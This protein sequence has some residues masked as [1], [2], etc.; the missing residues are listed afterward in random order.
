M[1]ATS[2]SDGDMPSR[3]ALVESQ[4]SAVT[5]SSPSAL[6]RATS[7]GALVNGC[8][9]SFQSAV[10]STVPRS[11]LMITAEGSGIEWDMLTSS[12]SNG[13]MV[14]RCPERHDMKR[15][16]REK[17]GLAEFRLQHRGGE[18]RRIDGHAAKPWP[19][20][21][22]GAEMILMR[23]GEEQGLQVRALSLEEADIGKDHVDA[24]L[25][26]AAEGD[27]QIDDEPL[28]VV[29]RP[30]AV[31]IEVHADLPHAAKGDEHELWP[32]SVGTSG[33]ALD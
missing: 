29:G 12:M 6:R 22:H 31:E 5:P 7:V 14:K 25:G 30:I 24:G 21:G 3:M 11:V 19:K 8:S 20:I 27:A 16:V 2:A 18:G 17:P 4:M 26:L 9:S 1:T 33:H 23:M 15:K 13:P 32:L 10:W 28:A